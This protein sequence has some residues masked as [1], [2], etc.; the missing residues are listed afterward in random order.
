MSGKAVGQQLLEAARQGNAKRVGS[1]LSTSKKGG[2]SS[3][4]VLVNLQGPDGWSSLLWGATGGRLDIVELL[5]D[6]GAD[7]HLGSSAQKSTALHVAAFSD[8]LPVCEYLLRKGADLR[9]R[10]NQK[11]TALDHYGIFANNHCGLDS[12]TLKLR[13]AALE[14]AW[15]DGKHCTANSRWVWRAPLVTLAVLLASLW[16][17]GGYFYAAPTRD[18]AAPSA[19]LGSG[20]MFDSIA[21]FY[22]TANLV[23]SFSLDQS[24][25]RALVD[26]LALPLEASSAE[27]DADARLDILDIATG[28]GD[29]AIMVA[30]DIVK[31]GLGARTSISGLDPSGGMLAYAHTKVD[32]RSLGSLVTLVQGSA[33]E[34]ADLLAA[35]G[36]R[37]KDKVTIS[38]GI[39]NFANRTKA[40]GAIRTVLKDPL[41]SQLSII[42][43][44]SPQTGLLAPLAR[45]FLVYGVPLLGTLVAGRGHGKEYQHLTDSILRFPTPA[46]FVDLMT[47]AGL[48]N[49]TARNV[50]MEVVYLFSCRGFEP[51]MSDSVG[52]I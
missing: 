37:L 27:A 50:F 40:L 14:A 52:N 21:P 41:S 19:R 44:V 2:G 45:A 5:C 7:I 3:L 32:A 29:V 28:T 23:M 34:P 10:D 36:G 15:A 11:R 51:E 39:R 24:W 42:E 12:E 4:A 46:G 48:R 9:A 18:P 17:G 20:A 35:G 38:F 26:E 43:F 13:R 22:D 25:R 1:L 30:Q 6:H 33:E 49:C 47:A 31:L 8:H 16:L